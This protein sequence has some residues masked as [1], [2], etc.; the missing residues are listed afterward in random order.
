[1]LPSQHG[2]VLADVGGDRTPKDVGRWPNRAEVPKVVEG[3][4]CYFGSVR[5][6]ALPGRRPRSLCG[7][8]EWVRFWVER[9]HWSVD[10]RIWNR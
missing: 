2:G 9:Q 6:R 5:A 8:F 3:G 10:L 1:M 4:S 7:G